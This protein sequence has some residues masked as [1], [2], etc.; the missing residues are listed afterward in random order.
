V[1]KAVV[2]TWNSG[3]LEAM[4]ALWHPEVIVRPDPY[5]PDSAVL[6]GED[7][8]LAFFDGLNAVMGSGGLTIVH[9]D[10][11]GDRCLLD[12][13]Q[14]M[15]GPG[16]GLTGTLDWSVITLVLDGRAVSI[17]FFLDRDRA[18]EAFAADR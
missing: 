11:R 9:Q 6:Y 2:E 1:A 18:H 14:R 12:V 8:A 7:E 15:E 16:S 3:E 13:V 5:F 4:P 17:E 10:E